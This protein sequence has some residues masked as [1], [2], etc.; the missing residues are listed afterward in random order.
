M[1]WPWQR[2]AQAAWWCPPAP[3]PDGDRVRHP[4]G[5]DVR[6]VVADLLDHGAAMQPSISRERAQAVCDTIW[7]DRA[8]ADRQARILSDAGWYVEAREPGARFGQTDQ[9]I[10]YS[11]Y[12]PQLLVCDEA[13]PSPGDI[14]YRDVS[15][16]P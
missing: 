4:D 3:I 16:T 2:R 5:R 8:A 13:P 9:L 11:V 14:T 7:P 1:Q 12:H 6:S 10:A 15:W